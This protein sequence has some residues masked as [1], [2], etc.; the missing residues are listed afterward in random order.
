M[1]ETKVL[2]HF[3]YA[4]KQFIAGQKRNILMFTSCS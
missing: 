2:M 3:N 4:R 1:Q